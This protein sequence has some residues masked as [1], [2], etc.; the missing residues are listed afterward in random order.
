MTDTQQEIPLSPFQKGLAEA[1]RK[2]AER[3][4]HSTLNA[5]K[6]LKRA[7][8]IADLDP[9]IAL[10]RAITAEE[11]AAT[12]LMIALRQRRYPGSR[13]LQPTR[14]AD[15]AGFSIMVKMVGA[16]FAESGWPNPQLMLVTDKKRPRIDVRI[17]G[18]SWGF[19][20]DQMIIPDEP[21]NLTV[22][23]SKGEEPGRLTLFEERFA[24]L[25]SEAGADSIKAHIETEANLRSALLYASDKGLMVVENPQPSI[26][27]R[28]RRTFI[29]IG[30]VII[31]LQSKGH[32][33]FAVQALQTY[34][35]ALGR[36][37]DD[38]FDYTPRGPDPDLLIEVR[39]TDG[40]EPMT[41]IRRKT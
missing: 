8:L 28:K 12:A 36:S 3:P 19:P 1:C 7:W 23:I 34:L 5:I 38:V 40:G 15:K 16:F 39:K 6:G 33:L 31:I 37:S 29:L 35:L 20:P 9:E 32:Q 27:E 25:A 41:T 14:H 30:L 17:P 24:A 10:F 2:L 13:A 21:L 4:R 18:K 22:K 11:E 26:L